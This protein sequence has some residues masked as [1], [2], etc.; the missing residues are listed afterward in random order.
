MGRKKRRGKN[1]PQTER[2]IHFNSG[3]SPSE[4][5]GFHKVHTQGKNSKSIQKKKAIKDFEDEKD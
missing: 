5:I 1:R 4:W 3:G 2:D